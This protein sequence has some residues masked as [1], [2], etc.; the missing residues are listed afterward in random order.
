MNNYSASAILYSRNNYDFLLNIKDICKKSTIN[1]IYEREFYNLANKVVKI[2]P[3]FIIIDGSTI[4]INK[5]PY[6]ILN[7]QIFENKMKIIILSDNFTCHNKL[8]SVITLKELQNFISHFMYK[9]VK[10][11]CQNLQ[12]DYSNKINN[13]LLK[14]NFPPNLKGK[15]YLT[16]CINLILNDGVHFRCLYKDC[17]PILAL[18][19]NTESN[20]IERDIR[21]SIKVAYNNSNNQEWQNYFDCLF[22]KIPS[23]KKFIYLC[24]DK[25][26]QEI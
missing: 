10:I 9:N 8:I 23:N 14:L 16:S 20:N 15:N 25:I 12:E 13:L 6:E 24:V 2:I 4:N 18:N 22:D 7:N 11:H 26:K 19:F 5:F 21:N 1:L 17:Y 3:D